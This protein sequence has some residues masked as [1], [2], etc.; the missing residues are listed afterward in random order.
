MLQQH[1]GSQALIISETHNTPAVNKETRPAIKGPVPFGIL[2]AENS[3]G[4]KIKL[5]NKRGK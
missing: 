5:S 2:S 3:A 4:N 1:W